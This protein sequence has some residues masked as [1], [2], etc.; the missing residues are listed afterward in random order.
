MIP[1][2][3]VDTY[4]AR[5]LWAEIHCI[6]ARSPAFADRSEVLGQL[7]AALQRSFKELAS[8]AQ[9]PRGSTVKR[10]IFP[11]LDIPMAEE[12]MAQEDD[13]Q[14]VGQ[15]QHSVHSLQGQS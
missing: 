6:C 3:Q 5:S 9:G 10:T 13:W 14:I 2:V 12:L 7:G 11:P 1:L 4:L 15:L 8:S